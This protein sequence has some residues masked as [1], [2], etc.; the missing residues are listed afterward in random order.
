MELNF[1]PNFTVERK[2]KK[3][4]CIIG[5]SGCVK[6]EFATFVAKTIVMCQSGSKVQ[7]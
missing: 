4:K 6:F 1:Y 2:E 3:K 5:Q 7:N